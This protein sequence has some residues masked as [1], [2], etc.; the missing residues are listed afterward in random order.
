MKNWFITGGSTGFGKELAELLLEKGD[1]VVATFR[2]A[3]QADAFTVRAA[4][5]GR[6]VVAD[7]SDE[8]QVKAAVAAGIEAL[9]H[10]DVVVNNAGY[11]SLGAV[12]AIDDAE[13]QRQF[14]VNVFGPLRVV[15]A[16]LPHLRS[17]RSGHILNITSIGGLQGMPAAG[18][19][20]GS[21][22]ALEGIGESLA[23]QL[24]PLGIRVTNVEPGPFR[25]DW[26]GRSA[27]LARMG[28]DDYA[29][30]DRNVDEIEGYSGTQ[31][32]DPARAAQA[33][34]D[35]VR[36]ENPPIHLPLG[37]MAYRVARAK[38]AAITK[39]FDTF[40]YLGLPT[41]FPAEK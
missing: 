23:R 20:N 21:K 4:G 33:M 12:E 24:E 25:T 31:I 11:G 10:L 29:H 22:F 3:A 14:D 26:A 41:D 36:I 16:V 35:L 7:V 34:Y 30:V 27:T 28:E 32:G 9:G 17:R 5:R 39:E 15:R 2:Q 19:Y 1:G 40:E 38:F 6:G 13:V 8:G 37:A 18:I